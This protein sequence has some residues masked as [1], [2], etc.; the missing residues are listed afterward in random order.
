MLDKIQ[1]YQT[2]NQ[3]LQDCPKDQIIVDNF[4]RAWSKINSIK[5]HKIVCSISG[6]SDSDIVIDICRRCD[7]EEKITY[8]WFDTGLEYQATKDHLKYLEEKYG[9]EIQTYKAIKPI[10]KCCKEYGQPFLSKQVSEFIMRLQN[11]GF[12]WEDEPIEILLKKYCKWDENKQDWVGCKSALMWWCEN[13][14]DNSKFNISRN[15]WLK[16][17]IIRNPPRF[18]IS[19]VCCNYAK[20]ALIHKVISSNRYDLNINGI[21]KSEGGVR[22]SAYKSCF[23]DGDEYDNYRPIF[24]YKNETKNTYE[25]KLQHK[26]QQMLYRIWAVKNRLFRLSVW[27]RF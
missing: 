8:V 9:I 7:K 11:Y 13:K 23:S 5:Y 15:K 24:W 27:K 2:L 17:F 3:L 12:Q 25:K 6:G 10:P 26:T 19:N 16:E 21:R 14:G 18:Q 22:A 20:K 1:P 4:I